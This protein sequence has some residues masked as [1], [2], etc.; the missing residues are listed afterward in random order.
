MKLLQTFQ[1]TLDLK[2]E[3]IISLWSHQMPLYKLQDIYVKA[4]SQKYLNE[5][6]GIPFF[7]DQLVIGIPIGSLAF[8]AAVRS[9]FAAAASLQQVR[10]GHPL[11]AVAGRKNAEHLNPGNRIVHHHDGCDSQVIHR[12]FQ[13][14]ASGCLKCKYNIPTVKY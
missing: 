12:N 8:L 10:F 13:G 4:F 9:Q 7:A 5:A 6:E 3:E 11:A 1:T 2:R 14:N